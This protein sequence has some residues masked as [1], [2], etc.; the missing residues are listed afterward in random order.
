MSVNARFDGLMIYF[1]NHDLKFSKIKSQ[2]PQ[3]LECFD[4]ETRFAWSSPRAQ[5]LTFHGAN[6][7]V[8]HKV[9]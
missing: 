5:T 9:N 4:C 2:I 8:A 1:E 6:G 7:T 3:M